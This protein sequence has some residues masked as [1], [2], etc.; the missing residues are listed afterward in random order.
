[1][2]GRIWMLMLC[3]IG[4]LCLIVFRMVVVMVKISGLFEDMIIMCL[5][6]DVIFSVC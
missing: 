5:F 1:M 3:Y 4:F 6:V 2:S